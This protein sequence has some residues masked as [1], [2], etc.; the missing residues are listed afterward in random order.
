MRTLLPERFEALWHGLGAGGDPEPHFRRLVRAHRQP[1]RAYH[2][3]AHVVDCLAH[4]DTYRALA[5]D[6]DAIEAALWY[7]DSIYVPWLPA[8]EARSAAWMRRIFARAGVGPGRIER[9]ERLILATRHAEPPKPGDEALVVDVDLAI[10]GAPPERYSRYEEEIRREYVWVPAT[11]Y[12][13][14][15][16]ALL[17]RFL[18]RPAIYATEAFHQR[19]E[20][21]ARENLERAIAE[22]GADS[23]SP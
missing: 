13:E 7:H 21:Q 6:P 18:E 15:R 20:A 14:G 17:R 22:L 4:L 2:G 8:N 11:R 12:H 9:I 5:A 3:E 1:W 16:T 19:Y 23:E 10:L